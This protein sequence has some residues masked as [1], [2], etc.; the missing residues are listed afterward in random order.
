[1]TTEP[2]PIHERS[3]RQPRPSH[4]GKNRRL[5][6]GMVIGALVAVFAFLN[7]GDVKVNWILGTGHS[8]LIIV[9]AVSFLLGVL[10][11]WLARLRR[12]SSPDASAPQSPR[13]P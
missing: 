6:A 3:D 4:A 8:P 1:M 10:V 7:L 13:R 12:K 2:T 9:I 5:V 11:S